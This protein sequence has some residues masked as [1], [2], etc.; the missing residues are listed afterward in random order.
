MLKDK[1]KHTSEPAKGAVTRTIPR[2]CL[3]GNSSERRTQPDVPLENAKKLRWRS[4]PL[5][6]AI[7]QGIALSTCQIQKIISFQQAIKQRMHTQPI[8]TSTKQLNMQ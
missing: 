4:F 7:L 6:N 1:E 3:R 8:K 5:S 2:C